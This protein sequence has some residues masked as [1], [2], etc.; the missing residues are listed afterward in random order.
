M[1]G[2]CDSAVITSASN[3]GTTR[4]YT[5]PHTTGHHH[6]R[7]PHPRHPSTLPVRPPHTATRPPGPARPVLPGCAFFCGF[8]SFIQGY[9]VTSCML[10]A[11]SSRKP[12]GAPRGGISGSVSCSSG[13]MEHMYS[14][15]DG[16]D[17]MKPVSEVAM[18]P[19]QHSTGARYR[20]AAR[21]PP[22]R[23]GVRSQSLCAVVWRVTVEVSRVPTR[24]RPEFGTV[25]DRWGLARVSFTFEEASFGSPARVG[26]DVKERRTDLHEAVSRVRTGRHEAVSRV[27]TS[28]RRTTL[29]RVPGRVERARRRLA[30]RRRRRP[31]EYCSAAHAAAPQ[32]CGGGRPTQLT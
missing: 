3:G 14:A 27:V 28:P 12:A 6:T 2:Y 5:N 7:P 31:Y 26:T 22:V 25:R 30:V 19:G 20:A 9:S 29:A 4:E 10:A 24:M 15:I 17:P 32:P 13:L 18:P 21:A 16:C 23:I 11:M 8:F 1:G